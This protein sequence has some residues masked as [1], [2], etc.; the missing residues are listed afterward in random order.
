MLIPCKL[1][2][3]DV[4]SALFEWIQSLQTSHWFMFSFCCCRCFHLKRQ[5]NVSW[6]KV[7]TIGRLKLPS[8]LNPVHDGK[9]K[10]VYR[11]KTLKSKAGI[12]K[13][14]RLLVLYETTWRT[15]PRRRAGRGQNRYD[16][17]HNLLNVPQMERLCIRWCQQQTE[18]NDTDTHW[19]FIL[20]DS[21]KAAPCH[22]E[23]AV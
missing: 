12:S 9:K 16:A 17:S 4:I 19:R 14:W 13:L 5:L 8:H 22:S 10:F 15:K 11:E 3:G 21:W 18:F 6:T 20:I 23:E 7:Q 2:C 1:I